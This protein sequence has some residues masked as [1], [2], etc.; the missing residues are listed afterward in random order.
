MVPYFQLPD[1]PWL[2]VTPF[3]YLVLIGLVCGYQFAQYRAQQYGVG[4]GIIREMTIF[5]AVPGLIGSDLL[6]P[7]FYRPRSLAQ[8]PWLMLRFFDGMSSFAGFLSFGLALAIY[9]RIRRPPVH[10]LVLADIAFQGGVV[11][12]IFGRLGC[13]VTHDHPGLRSNFILAVQYPEGG[14]HDLGWYDFLF[15][16]FII[17]PISVAIHRSRQFAGTQVA[18]ISLLYATFRI[19]ADTLRVNEIR[20]FHWA[21]GQ[22]S[23]LVLLVVGYWAAARVKKMAIPLPK[24]SQGPPPK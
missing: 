20:Y 22:I 3:T 14:R 9:L 7:L 6:Q 13:T 10:W 12:W 4:K 24:P 8:D 21:P 5:A 16:T 17:F 15:T 2:N 18:V 11:F 19:F 23:A 1:L